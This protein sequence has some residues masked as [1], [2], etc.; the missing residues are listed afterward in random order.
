MGANLQRSLGV[1][2]L[3]SIA[4]GAMI[5]S[6]LFVLPGLAFAAS[7]PAVILAY[8][9]AAV[10]VVPSM[11]AQAELATAMPRSGG[12]YFFIDRSLGSLAGTLAGLAN[13]FSIAFKGAFALTGIG[14]L[15]QILSPEMSSLH[16]RLAAGLICLFFAVVNLIS[17]RHTGRFQV[18]LVMALLGILA[19][20]IAGGMG[21][22]GIDQYRGFLARGWSSVLGTVGIIFVSFGGLT[23]I[24]GVAAET[25]DPGRNIP[26]AIILAF[27]VVS[28]IYVLAVAVTVGILPAARLIASPA[29]LAQAAEVFWGRPGLL[30]LAL[31]A[32]IAFFTTAN[33]ALLAASRAPMQMSRDGLLPVMFRRLTAGGTPGVSILATTVLMLGVVLFFDLASL[34]KTAS[35]LMLLLFISVNISVVIMRESR[36]HSYRPLFRAPLCPWLQLA[37]IL[38]Y[39]LLIVEM[40]TVPLLITGVFLAAGTT[41]YFIYARRRVRRSS[42]LMHVVERVTAR[43]L[44]SPTLEGE[45]KEIIVDRDEIVEDRFDRIIKE[46]PVLDLPARVDS[47]TMLAEV[48]RRL[49]PRLGASEAVLRAKFAERERQSCTVIY[50]GLALP[51]VLVEGKGLFEIM[52]V[53]GREGIDFSCVTD[54]VFAVFVLAG[55]AD[56]RNFHLRA[57]MAIAQVSQEPDFFRRW[58]AAR[59]EAE[60]R[61]IILL[62]PRCRL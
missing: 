21:K 60:L 14:V 41:W 17:V 52:L 43:E 24:A 15:L 46:C 48:S 62:S 7:G 37:A 26:R 31:A 44:K 4:A 50:P 59:D 55:S 10:L 27:V 28:L 22:V 8:F 1:A 12:T 32:G 16:G 30:L 56:E 39:V 40:G 33:A 25:R 20:F 23:K 6:G 9:L 54:P 2:D 51:H 29:P 5:S 35:T 34:A 58:Q 38:V 13:W 19:A 42:A 18:L 36:I 47:S 49:V 45:L 3:F 57:L 53:R 11:L 61:N